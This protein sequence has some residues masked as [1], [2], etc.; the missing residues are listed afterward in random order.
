ML[1]NE[2]TNEKSV[3]YNETKGEE[4]MKRESLILAVV[5][6]TLAV[7]LT[8]CGGRGDRAEAV[9]RAE[10]VNYEEWIEGYWIVTA[11]I[12]FFGRMVNHERFR[13]GTIY[14]ISQGSLSYGSYIDD[15][16]YEIVG[17]NIYI[18]NRIRILENVSELTPAV[19]WEIRFYGRDRFIVSKDGMEVEYTRQREP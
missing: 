1:S 12:P 15:G 14:T 8:G 7:M 19:R 10:P 5:C 11:E 6:I 16:R 2:L 4:A 9:T 18:Q 17:N 3:E 13:N